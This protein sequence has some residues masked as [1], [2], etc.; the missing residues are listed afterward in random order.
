MLIVTGIF[1]GS[2]TSDLSNFLSLD[3][4]GQL[5]HT[6]GTR[7]HDPPASVCRLGSV[8]RASDK[9][10]KDSKQLYDSSYALALDTHDQHVVLGR[11]WLYAVQLALACNSP[12]R[13][14]NWLRAA[15]EGD[16]AGALLVGVSWG[17]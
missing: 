1:L 4:A 16:P 15:V 17:C 12:S 11:L 6:F 3:Q 13:P 7:L 2:F 8:T 10:D 5:L 9:F 14:H